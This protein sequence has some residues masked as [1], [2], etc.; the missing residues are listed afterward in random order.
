[1][2]DSRIAIVAGTGLIGGS[3]G[4][5]LRAGGWHV[6]G[7]E[8]DRGRAATAVE[9]GAV[10][11]LGNPGPCD[12]AVIATPVNEVADTAWRLLD[13]GA[14]VVTDVAGVKGPIAAAVDHACFVPGHPMAGNEQDGLDGAS[15]DLFRD[16][17]WVLTPTERTE[18][19]VLARVREVVAG[20]GAQVIALSPQRHDQLVAVVSHVPHLAAAT[21]MHLADGRSVEHR[22]LLRLAAGGFRDMTR[23]AAGHPAIWPDVCVGNRA[24]VTDVLDELMVELSRLRNLVAAGDRAGLLARLEA[25]REARRN[26]PT[27]APEPAELTEIRVP[28]RDET[29]QLATITTLAADLDVNIYDL[30]IVHSSEGP[31]GVILALVDSERAERFKAGL[32][33]EG[34]RP[35]LAALE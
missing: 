9:I 17:V 13:G 26:L 22:A 7:M 16:A 5:A 25:A 15:P 10:D 12:L 11:E 34:Y 6:V 27:T 1:M 28:V 30:E 18:D 3:V 33:A 29:G 21:L 2:A 20:F 8:P 19:T 24:A 14:A 4:L 23:V 32:T 35:T 31:L